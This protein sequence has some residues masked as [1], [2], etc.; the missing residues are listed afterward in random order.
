VHFV[1]EYIEC[2]KMHDVNNI[3]FIE[4]CQK[5]LECFCFLFFHLWKYS[6]WMWWW[7]KVSGIPLCPL[8]SRGSVICFYIHK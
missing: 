1:G 8:W 5:N 7:H 6:G 4:I 3:K 2:K